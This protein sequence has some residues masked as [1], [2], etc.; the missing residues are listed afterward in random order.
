MSPRFSTTAGA[1]PSA[2]SVGAMRTSCWCCRTGAA[3]THQRIPGVFWEFNDIPLELVERIEVVRGPG[4]SIWG[5]N[6]VNGVINIITRSAAKAPGTQIVATAGSEL[7]GSLFA[8]HRVALSE[9][10]RAGGARQSRNTSS[11]PRRSR[12]ARRADF[13]RL[14]GGLRLDGKAGPDAFR[15]QGSVR[16]S[17][18]GDH[19]MQRTPGIDA[20]ARDNNSVSELAY[21][22]GRWEGRELQRRHTAQPA[23]LR[24]EVPHRQP[25]RQR[26]SQHL[27]FRIR[28]AATPWRARRTSSGAATGG[29]RA[30]RSRA[31]HPMC[32]STTPRDQADIFSL[33]AQGEFALVPERWAL[34]LGA[35]ADLARRR[36]GCLS[37]Q[38][39][40]PVHAGTRPTACGPRWRPRGVRTASQA[41]SR[42]QGTLPGRAL[43]GPG[44]ASLRDRHRLRDQDRRQPQLGSQ[45]HVDAPRPGLARSVV[46]GAEHRGRRLSLPLRRPAPC[47]PNRQPATDLR[48]AAPLR[49]TG[50]PGYS[51]SA[52]ASAASSVHHHW[53][54]TPAWDLAASLALNHLD[55]SSVDRRRANSPRGRPSAS[56]R[57]APATRSRP[58]CSGTPGCATR[59][60]CTPT[61]RGRA[62]GGSA[63]DAGHASGLEGEPR[64]GDFQ[65]SARRPA[66]P[67]T[68]GSDR[69]TPAL[70]RERDRRAAFTC[71]QT[72][73]SERAHVAPSL[74]PL[75]VLRALALGA[76]SPF[77]P[78][79][80]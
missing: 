47:E 45:L 30:T 71:E 32:G 24:R 40:P 53:R 13:W 49:A 4:A 73:A 46:A 26:A 61:P 9:Q 8:S 69:R 70:D 7:R 51:P 28:A 6:A 60:R 36:Q 79:C 52:P 55:H 78:G 75:P 16:D 74:L 2:V 1:C 21:L 80:G 14:A 11:P 64:P 68:S 10:A 54:P 66:R 56:S 20:P 63:L 5:A 27:R 41:E 39:P 22:L 72:G 50:P 59:A 57:C 65:S 67:S 76:H 38:R 48:T 12:T 18:A 23:G 77:R 62:A 37:A 25:H 19:F 29:T 31:A 33:F 15:L 35:R 17:V 42:R 44:S 3:C 34:I 58:P 43:A